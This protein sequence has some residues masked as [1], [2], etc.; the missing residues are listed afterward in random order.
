YD[1]E[2]P[3]MLVYEFLCRVTIRSVIIVKAGKPVGLINRGSLLRFFSNLLPVTQA[4]GL[5]TNAVAASQAIAVLSGKIG[6]RKRIGYLVRSLASEAADMAR[7]V[8]GPS[9]NLI[10]TVVGGA[11][12]LQELVR[13]LLILTRFADEA[14]EAELLADFD[15]SDQPKAGAETVIAASCQETMQCDRQQVAA[16][17]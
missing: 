16:L 15:F 3:A 1:E 12:S 13:D 9:A 6:P 11:T 8:H 14:A 7:R 2:T 4:S 10:P 5:A 17:L